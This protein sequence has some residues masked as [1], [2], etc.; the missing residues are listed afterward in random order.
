MYAMLTKLALRSHK[1]L[2]YYF[3]I[4]KLGEVFQGRLFASDPHIVEENLQLAFMKSVHVLTWFHTTNHLCC[5]FMVLH[6]ITQC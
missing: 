4:L 5:R 6:F 3:T 2:K 1:H